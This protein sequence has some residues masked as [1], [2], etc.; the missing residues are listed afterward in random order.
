MGFVLT[1]EQQMLRDSAR[2]FADEK[3]PV[4]Q[5]RAL[6]QKGG[7]EGYDKAAWKEM[8]DLGFAGVIVP[9]EFGGSGF[10]YVGLGQVLEAQGRTIASSPL[11]STALIGAS[12]LMLAGNEKQKAAYLPK[13]ASGDL[14]TALAVDEGPHHD[15][16]HIATTA[17]KSGS[18]FT[19]S[20]EKRYVVDGAAADLLIVAARTSGK[21]GD[22]TGITLFLVPG[23]AKGITRVAL[24]T[25]DAHP[26]ANVSFSDVQV[27]ADAVL[28]AVDSGYGTL[29]AILDRARIGL[30]AE[31]LGASDAAF[32]MT[33]EY[34][35]VRKQFGQLIGS[36]QSLQHRA[37]IMFTELELTRSCV[38]AAL[39]ALD[40][41]ANNIPELA[42]LAKAR[43]GETL[44]L[45]SNETVQMHGGIGMTDA[46]DS[47]LYMK[48]ARVLEALY[49]SEAFHRDRYA[50]LGGY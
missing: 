31:M 50:R 14:I 29:E 37:A 23:S 10:G 35:K 13:I 36:F 6:R 9:E 16:S 43:A 15:P 46:H 19:L 49:G 17:K 24:K 27:G 47:G 30:A 2:A 20:G 21:P 38:A 42:S 4:S 1:E 45:V 22:A 11:I 12:A 25:L 28:G 39:D 26:A 48:R 18:G 44:H 33:S 7:E 32:E 5:L 34:L 3:L 8:V 40:R 41:N